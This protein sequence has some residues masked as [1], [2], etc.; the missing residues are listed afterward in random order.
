M[1]PYRIGTRI[2]CE[3][4]GGEIIGRSKARKLCPDITVVEGNI[5]VYWNKSFIV[6]YTHDELTRHMADGE[7]WITQPSPFDR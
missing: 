1:I 5:I 3:W 7:I 2:Q 4:C 6:D